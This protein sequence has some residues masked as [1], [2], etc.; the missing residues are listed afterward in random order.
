MLNRIRVKTVGA[1]GRNLAVA[2]GDVICVSVA[3]FNLIDDYWLVFRGGAVIVKTTAARYA[4]RVYPGEPL[5][6]GLLVSHSSGVRV[7]IPLNKAERPVVSIADYHGPVCF[8][9]DWYAIAREYLDALSGE[10]R[11]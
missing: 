8:Q 9:P 11:L 5:A 6:D 1:N 3:T 4:R 7:W 2:K 10:L